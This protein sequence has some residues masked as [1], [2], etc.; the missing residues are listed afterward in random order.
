MGQLRQVAFRVTG[1]SCRV[2]LAAEFS[3]AL[4][5]EPLE[6]REFAKVH[7][8]FAKLAIVISSEGFRSLICT[9][10]GRHHDPAG[11]EQ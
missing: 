8:P 7:S 1:N 10:A 4:A 3:G 5:K 11:D 6:S 2:N 9:F